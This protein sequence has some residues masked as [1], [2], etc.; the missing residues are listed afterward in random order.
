M[1]ARVVNNLT[2]NDEDI[3][4]ESI[5]ILS[6]FETPRVIYDLARKTCSL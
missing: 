3:A 4:K 2:R 1:I 6:A 5:S